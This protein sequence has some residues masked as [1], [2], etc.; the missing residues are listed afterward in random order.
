MKQYRDV[1]VHFL[2]EGKPSTSDDLLLVRKIGENTVRV[3]YT[4]N[5][6]N[7]KVSEYIILN[8]NQYLHYM[9]RLLNLLTLDDD[10]FQSVQF[11]IPSYPSI[12]FNVSHIQAKMNTILEW[13]G[14]TCTNWPRIA[15]RRP[16]I[17]IPSPLPE[18][19]SSATSDSESTVADGEE[20]DGEDRDSV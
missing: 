11:M 10:P 9:Y 13:L 2:R 15:N 6:G 7:S 16:V 1:R 17:T 19:E 18:S 4:E 5:F 20:G 14:N 12:L 8:Y 3:Q